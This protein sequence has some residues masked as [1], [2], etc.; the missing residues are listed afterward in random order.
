MLFKSFRLL[1]IYIF[2]LFRVE[3]VTWFVR[4]LSIYTVLWQIVSH[5]LEVILYLT[6]SSEIVISGT[7]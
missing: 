7:G 2:F 1:Y 6:A 3:S 5:I 4:Y